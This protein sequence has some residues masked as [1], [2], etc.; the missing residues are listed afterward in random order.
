MW[1]IG[2]CHFDP[3]CSRAVCSSSFLWVHLWSLTWRT[4]VC[5][6]PFF[7]FFRLCSRTE[8]Q[9]TSSKTSSHITPTRC[10]T[11]SARRTTPFLLMQWRR[12]WFNFMSFGDARAMHDGGNSRCASCTLRPTKR[13]APSSKGQHICTCPKN[14]H[15]LDS[16]V[17]LPPARKRTTVRATAAAKK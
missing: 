17:P 14:S 12:A 9:R 16:L 11:A 5:M 8:F 4:F 2:A 3:V 15:L 13:Q 10:H 6:H 7:L 1:C